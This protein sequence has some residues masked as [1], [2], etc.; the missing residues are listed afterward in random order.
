MGNH[1]VM[2]FPQIWLHLSTSSQ[3]WLMEHNGEPLPDDLIAEI[4]SVTGGEQNAQWWTGPSVEGGDTAHRRGGGLDRD[5]RQRRPELIHA[6][7]IQRPPRGKRAHAA[8]VQTRTPCAS[9]CR[10]PPHPT[11][12][13]DWSVA[14]CPCGSAR[15][16]LTGRHRPRSPPP[17]LFPCSR[18]SGSCT[19]PQANPPPAHTPSRLRFDG[20]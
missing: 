16:S 15:F 12:S 11:M 5:R 10:R 2:D 7:T 17:V 9:F 1:G 20:R 6:P 19:G 13:V 18:A 3:S 14:R 4:L 8:L